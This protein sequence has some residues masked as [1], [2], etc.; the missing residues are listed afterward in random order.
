MA[1]RGSTEHSAGEAR[2]TKHQERAVLVDVRCMQIL[3]FVFY[4]TVLLFPLLV[5]LAGMLFVRFN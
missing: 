2:V 1:L 4:D 5:K 3:G